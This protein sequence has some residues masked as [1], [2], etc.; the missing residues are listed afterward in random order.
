MSRSHR[1][2]PA[3]LWLVA[4][5]LL[6]LVA[7]AASGQGAFGRLLLEVVDG[8]GQPLA[9]VVVTATSEELPD[10]NEQ[11][12][13]NKRGVAT[14]AFP[15]GTK[16]YD[17]EFQYG[18]LAPIQI[19]FKPVIRKSVK[20]RVRID[21]AAEAAPEQPAA[22]VA[23]ERVYSAA[24]RLF[25][26]GVEA[27][28]SGDLEA[29]RTSFL[30]AL[31]RDPAMVAAHSALGAVYIELGQPEA[32]IESANE[33][34]AAQPESPRGFRILYEAHTAL[35]QT[36][37]AERALSK[38]AAL[39]AGGDTPTIVYNEG[40][41]AL[42][43]GDVKRA[44]ALFR[45]A[46]E[47]DPRL[48][49]A[50]SALAILLF[51]AEKFAQAAEAAERLMEI[52]PA[53]ATG[54]RLA[55]EAYAAA[56]DARQEAAFERLVAADPAATA[57]KLFERGVDRFNAGE[58][59]SAA[60]DFELALRADPELARGHYYLGLCK[61]NAGDTAA[62]REHLERFLALA[63]NDD[64]AGVARQILADLGS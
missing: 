61:V 25:N 63:P 10:F 58:V 38:M 42:Q 8:D 16:V 24:E 39:D 48:A 37:E 57:V 47:L 17:L 27:L 46:V 13:T 62:A 31:E 40:V 9:G 43:V 50:W 15:D 6:A 19:S 44:E 55:F 60:D 20:R 22:D 5:A 52:E 64:D 53:N 26:E 11:K 32:A 12:T 28:K 59:A 54:L 2:A 35:G 23:Q 34:L 29:A 21:L 4:A 1:R 18:E 14:L 30:E 49:P 56:G 51:N 33:L 45:Q 36:D 3:A 7:G 41:S